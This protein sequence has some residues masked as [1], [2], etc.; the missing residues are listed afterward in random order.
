MVHGTNG[1]V[2]T[3]RRVVLITPIHSYL[4]GFLEG[5]YLC[6]IQHP[7]QVRFQ[8][9]LHTFRNKELSASWAP[10]MFL[11]SLPSSL[12]SVLGGHTGLSSMSFPFPKLSS[13]SYSCCWLVLRSLTSH[14]TSRKADAHRGQGMHWSTNHSLM[15]EPGTKPSMSHEGKDLRRFGSLT[16]V[17]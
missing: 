12:P 10:Y 9:L 2:P 8:P 4:K 16:V 17:S 6:P 5:W 14:S 15:P 13:L 3:W 7:S 1:A 11:S